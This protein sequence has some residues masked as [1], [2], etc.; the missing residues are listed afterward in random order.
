MFVLVCIYAELFIAVLHW[1]ACVKIV[2]CCALLFSTNTFVVLVVL[3][4]IG[5]LFGCI[6]AYMFLKFQLFII[7]LCGVGVYLY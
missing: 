2:C 1:C 6:G 7:W 4:L 3:V 5:G